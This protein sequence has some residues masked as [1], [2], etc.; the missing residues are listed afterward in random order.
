MVLLF[1]LQLSLC[2]QAEWGGGFAISDITSGGLLSRQRLHSLARHTLAGEWHTLAGEVG[3][4]LSAL[5]R[6]KRETTD[7][8]A[9]LQ[10]VRVGWSPFC[11]SCASHPSFLGIRC[12]DARR[13]EQKTA[14]MPSHNKGEAKPELHGYHWRSK[15][16]H[17]LQHGFLYGFCCCLLQFSSLTFIRY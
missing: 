3:A 1:G 5:Q 13:K 4:S 17:M 15:Y 14:G 2:L 11:I 6:E 7:L 9:L 12:T 16:L 10:S 8:R